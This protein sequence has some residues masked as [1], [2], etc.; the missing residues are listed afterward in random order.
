MLT[1]EAVVEKT[2][3]VTGDASRGGRLNEMTVQL[4]SSLQ[5]LYT[6]PEERLCP[7]IFH[8]TILKLFPFSGFLHIQPVFFSS[9]IWLF[10]CRF[11]EWNCLFLS[12]THIFVLLNTLII[13]H[14]YNV[15]QY[16]SS[17]IIFLQYCSLCTFAAYKSTFVTLIKQDMHVLNICIVFIKPGRRFA[18][19]PGISCYIHYLWI[20]IW[21]LT[22]HI[23]T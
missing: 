13:P 10:I 5:S 2:I 23:E 12:S 9:W 1:A 16:L 19:E 6:W 8:P 15:L 17:N 3:V 7:C 11:V 22:L 18:F 20:K 21:L 14:Y 4:A